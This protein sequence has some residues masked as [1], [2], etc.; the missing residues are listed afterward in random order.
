MVKLMNGHQMALIRLMC[1]PSLQPQLSL[2]DL[3]HSGSLCVCVGGCVSAV[4]VVV[5]VVFEL[6]QVNRRGRKDAASPL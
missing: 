6:N 2:G 1:S 5:I 3:T 4:V